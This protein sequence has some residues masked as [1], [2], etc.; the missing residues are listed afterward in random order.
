MIR[1]I[2]AAALLCGCAPGAPSLQPL[3]DLEYPWG[4]CT[5]DEA[6]GYPD[7]NCEESNPV[8]LPLVAVV[9]DELGN[10]VEDETVTVTSSAE[11]I[12]VLPDAR[13]EAIGLPD[14]AAWNATWDAGELWMEPSGAFEGGDTWDADAATDEHGR[15]RLHLFVEDP[16]RD[17]ANVPQSSTATVSIAGDELELT[18]SPIL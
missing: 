7:I 4:Y 3:P 6:T 16:P 13:V 12:F 1:S 14:A 10:P 5:L 18:L 2:A 15:I 17:S 9:Y 11:G 8:L